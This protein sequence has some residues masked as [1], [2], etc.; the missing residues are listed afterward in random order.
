MNYLLSGAD[1][2]TH[3]KILGLALACSVIIGFAFNAS[4]LAAPAPKPELNDVRI[5]AQVNN[6]SVCRVNEVRNTPS[7]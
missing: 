7:I 2:N 5:A 4:L 1:R 3:L 6:K